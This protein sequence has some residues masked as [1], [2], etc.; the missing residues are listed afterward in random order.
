[1]EIKLIKKTGVPNAE[2]AAHKQI[3]AE[4]DATTFSKGW[5]FIT[6]FF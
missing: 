6:E 2:I 4:F 5:A 3:Q 1:M